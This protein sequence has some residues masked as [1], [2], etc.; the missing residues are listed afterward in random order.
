MRVTCT[1]SS[2]NQVHRGIA[3]AL[4]LSLKQGKLRLSSFGTVLPHFCPRN[5]ICCLFLSFSRTLFPG[6]ELPADH[7]LRRCACS[8]VGVKYPRFIAGWSQGRSCWRWRAAVC[9]SLQSDRAGTESK[10]GTGDDAIPIPS[11]TQNVS[12]FVLFAVPCP[13]RPAECSSICTQRACNIALL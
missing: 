5:R 4:G 3:S 9:T 11:I 8:G 6:V 13:T 1:R 7:L 10:I 2:E 12:L